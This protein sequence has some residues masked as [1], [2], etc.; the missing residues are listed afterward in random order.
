MVPRLPQRSGIQLEEPSEQPPLHAEQHE[1]VRPSQTLIS[2]V[3]PAGRCNCPNYHA[4]R[5]KMHTGAYPA[6]ATNA[7][8]LDAVDQPCFPAAAGT[9]AAAAA[10]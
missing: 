10:A 8:A 2:V 9:A 3:P 4:K 7:G 6:A 1:G 5:G